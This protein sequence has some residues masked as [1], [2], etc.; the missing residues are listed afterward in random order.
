VLSI[1]ASM[2]SQS[3]SGIDMDN[4]EAAIMRR[5]VSTPVVSSKCGSGTEHL[6]GSADLALRRS[7]L[8]I[9]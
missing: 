7:V 6:A 9:R 1:T 2:N 4:P 8:A 5:G 3:R